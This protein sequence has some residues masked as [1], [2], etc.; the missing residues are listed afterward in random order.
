MGETDA[1][2]RDREL[3]VLSVFASVFGAVIVFANIA[4]GV[5][6]ESVLGLVVPAGTIAYAITFIITDI[7]DELWGKKRA[8]YIV[9]GGLAAELAML[10]LIGID[11]RIP[12]IDPESQELYK[13]VFSPQ[14]RIVLASIVAYLVAQHHDVW[15]FWKLRELTGGRLLWLR[16]NVS[17]M[18]S[19]LIDTTIFVTIAFAGEYPLAV[20]ANMIF[21]TWAFKVLIAAVD[22]PVVYAGVSLVRNY[23]QTGTL[24]SETT[25]R[26]R[27]K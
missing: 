6:L 5:K 21:A 3:L 23:V 10:G 18:A 11:Y 9:W 7:V 4:A 24:L 1:G 15:A 14:Y 22:T 20:L 17:T 19:Q 25:L 8:V 26:Y 12:A 13:T 16:N 27:M 2:S